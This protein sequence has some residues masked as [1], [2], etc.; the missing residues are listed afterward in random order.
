MRPKSVVEKYQRRLFYLRLFLLAIIGA[1]TLEPYL[2]DASFIADVSSRQL[3]PTS[4]TI[5]IVGLACWVAI[6]SFPLPFTSPSDQDTGKTVRQRLL[7]ERIKTVLL[8]LALTSYL[9]LLHAKA[10]PPWK[11]TAAAI[12]AAG[13]VWSHLIL[14][15]EIKAAWREDMRRRKQGRG[16][17]L[18]L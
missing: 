12:L 3:V 10:D 8:I 6:V 14:W 18:G 2:N 11:K 15:P 7:Q 1:T 9:F 13:L 16:W 4:L 17:R 5:V